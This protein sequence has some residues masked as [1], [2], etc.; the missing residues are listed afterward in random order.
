M[1]TD[2]EQLI[3]NLEQSLKNNN[4][5]YLLYSSYEKNNLIKYTINDKT[6][7]CDKNP[8]DINLKNYDKL[9]IRYKYTSTSGIND[10]HGIIMYNIWNNKNNNV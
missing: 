6:Y 5:I 9:N 1:Q 10:I 8:S 2:C 4:S 3:L 7:I